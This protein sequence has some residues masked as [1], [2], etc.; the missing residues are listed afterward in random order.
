VAFAVAT[1]GLAPPGG[2]VP[3]AAAFHGGA[4]GLPSPPV[5][6]YS[7]QSYAA[8]QA[9]AAPPGVLPAQS[10][11]VAAGYAQPL[12]VLYE[13]QREE[14]QRNRGEV[15]LGTV[16]GIPVRVHVLLPALTILYTLSAALA[17][18]SHVAFLVFWLVGP[19]LWTTVLVHELGH[20]LAARKV[21]G[22]V[23]SILLWPLG[24]LAYI[25]H[26]GSAREDLVIAACGPLTHGPQAAF[27]AIL[28]AM[29]RKNLEAAW[30]FRSALSMQLAL[31]VFNL[32]PAYPLDGGRIVVDV[33]RMRSVPL[34]RAA[35]AVAG[36]SVATGLGVVIYGLVVN[37]LSS[38]LVGVWILS[39]AWDLLTKTRAG[40]A[41]QHPMF[42]NYA[43]AGSDSEQLLR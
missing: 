18:G 41:A 24:G 20:C 6:G 27:W 38:I 28:L 23:D 14:Q 1:T 8:A 10:S 12:P 7:P 11:Y 31:F 39:Q 25:A 19:I 29:G 13:E 33:M 35:R 21:G 40:Q 9:F 42:A 26:S 30:V 32:C 17:Y 34:D 4:N 43:A 15:P 36:L 2:H 5:A 37:A 3:G 22:T 16:M